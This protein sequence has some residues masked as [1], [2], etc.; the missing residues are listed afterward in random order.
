MRKQF[1]LALII[2]TCICIASCKKDKTETPP[3]LDEND[4]QF[5]A[6]ANYYKGESDQSNDDIN[7]ALK[8]I[9]AFRGGSASLP[10]IL[11]S[12]LC[13]VTID[14]TLID[15]LI[16]VFNFDGITPC[17]SPTRTRS[18]Q[19]KVRLISGSH[20][21]DVN[22][23]LTIE[24]INFKV[25]RLYDNK[26]IKFNGT[27]TLQNVNGNNWL[28]FILGTSTLE[29][30]ERANNIHV[31]F[32]NGSNATWNSARTT[33]WSYTPS[34]GRITFT[35]NGDT[36][37]NGYS[38]V[39]S[40]GV[41]RFGYNFTTKYNTAVAS[42]T[43]CGLW[44][45]TSGELVHYVNNRSFVLTLGVDQSGNPST[46]DCAYGYKVT[47]TPAGGTQTSLVFSY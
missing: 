34:N 41:N 12:P 20:W 47:W 45:F 16:L 31:E 3:V 18:G 35:A 42:N 10:A 9:P 28:G 11:S 19:I 29:Y 40:W 30:R 7:T 22:A 38:T 1:L 37:M 15:S 32:D 5:N 17:F 8:D 13:G 2:G 27:K 21:S 46:L 23:M 43:Y 14:S 39:D 26:S 33:Q 6:D 25:T 4:K 24:Y 36:A 44:N